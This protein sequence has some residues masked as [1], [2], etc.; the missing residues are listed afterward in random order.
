MLPRDIDETPLDDPDSGEKP[1]Y[2]MPE[3]QNDDDFSFAGAVD[4]VRAD[5][6]NYIQK[7]RREAGRRVLAARED[8]Q[9][10]PRIEIV[11]DR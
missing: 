2:L 6:A 5:D 1:G 4:D 3:P 10:V 7:K 8:S 9:I 11:F